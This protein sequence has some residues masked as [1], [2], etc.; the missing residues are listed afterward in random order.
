MRTCIRS[1]QSVGTMRS[2]RFPGGWTTWRS[3]VT[4]CPVSEQVWCLMGVAGL[5][6]HRSVCET[7]VRCSCHWTDDDMGRRDP[8]YGD[9]IWFLPVS[10]AL[11][12]PLPTPSWATATPASWVPQARVQRAM[13]SGLCT[14]C[15]A[16]VAA[17]PG[18]QR[19]SCPLRL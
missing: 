9:V 3:R 15:P 12:W 11:S 19:A 18:E 10:P 8:G 7:T 17:A 4:S 2:P 16:C 14:H 13:P 5:Q 6:E 1:E